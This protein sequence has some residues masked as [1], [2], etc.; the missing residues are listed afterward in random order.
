MFDESLINRAA[1][2]RREKSAGISDRRISERGRV[3]S[4]KVATHV[5]PIGLPRKTRSI[6]HGGNVDM[7]VNKKIS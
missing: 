3:G 1:R 5:S 7:R 2:G 6:S 4:D